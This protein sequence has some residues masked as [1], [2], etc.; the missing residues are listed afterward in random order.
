MLNTLIQS[1]ILP[2]GIDNCTTIISVFAVNSAAALTIVERNRQ[3]YDYYTFLVVNSAA[4]T[5]IA[6]YAF[7]P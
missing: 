4:V 3:L 7:L 5:K 6:N 2:K 1:R